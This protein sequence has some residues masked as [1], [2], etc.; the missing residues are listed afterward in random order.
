MAGP[1]SG[2]SK[3]ELSGTKVRSIANSAGECFPIAVFSGS[4]RT[5]NPFTCGSGGGDND[6]QQCFPSQAWGKRYLT[7]PTSTA[8]SAAVSMTNAYKIAVKDPTTNVFRN[9][10][11]IPLAT[12]QNGTYYYFESN[13]AQYITSDKPIMV[14]QYM[15]GGTACAGSGT[16]DPEMMYISPVEQGIK[17]V[18]FYRNTREAITVNYLTLIIPTAGISSL[19]IDGTNTFSH[20]Y[21][22]PQLPG[23]SV[24]VRR[25]TA[26]QSQAIVQSDSAFTAITYGLGG[27]ESYGYNAGTLINNLSAVGSIYNTSDTSTTTVSHPF[28]CTSTPVKLSVLLGY[29]TPPTRLVWQLSQVGGGLSPNTDI[30]QNNPSPVGTQVI[31][32]ISYFKFDLPTD[33]TFTTAGTY[34]IPL[35]AT[36]PSI[37]NCNN[38]ERVSYDIEVRGKPST[39]FAVT[40]TGCYLDTVFLTG[41]TVSANGFNINQWLYTFPDASTSVS[42]D[43]SKRFAA[44]GNYNVRLRIVSTE[45]CVGDTTKTISLTA[46][47]IV[48]FASTSP[49]PCQGSAFTFT[50][51]SSYT[52]T[53]SLNNS[54]WDF[55]DGTIV[56]ASNVAPI[57]HTYTSYGTF[58]VRHSAGAGASCIGDTISQTITVFAPPTTS[59]TYPA[60]CLPASGTVNFTSTASTPDGQAITGHLWNFGDPASGVNNTS[61]LPNPTHTYPGFGSYTITYR[62]TTANGCTKDTTVNATLNLA[63]TFNYP[64][65]A[66][67]CQNS[68]TPISVATATVTN[69]VPGAGIYRGPG[70]NAAGN[71]N[72][73]TAGAGA[74][75]IWY[76]YTTTANCIDSVSQTITVNPTPDASFAITTAA[77][78]PA[79]GIVPFNYN[80]TALPGQT[81]LWNFGD[82]ASGAN[83]TSTLANPTHNYTTGTYTISLRVTSAAGCIKDSVVTNTFNV[84]PALNYPA[85]A[86]VCESLTGTISVA[87]ATVTNGATGTGVYSGPGV[88]AAGNFSPSAAGDGTH[89]IWYVFTATGNCIDSISQTIVVHPTPDA[90]F[91][92]TT[93]ACLPASGIVPF[94]YNGTALPGQTYLWNFGDPASGLNN[95]SIIANPTHNYATGTYTISLR[96]TSA[97]GCVK[98]SVVTNTFSV[99][100]ALNYPA[101]AAVCESVVGTI[102]VATATVT[103][104][105]LGTGVYSGPGTDAA[106]NFNPSVAGPGT[107]TITYTFTST[108]NCVATTTQTI[109][110][111]AK[112]NASFTY[113]TAACLPTTGIATFTYNGTITA[114]QTYIWNFGDP[115]SGANNTST[116]A[117]PTH[118]YTNTG[119]YSVSVRVTNANGC[120][121]DSVITTTFSVTPALNYPALTAVCESVTGTVSVATAT[122]TN[123]VLGTGVYSGPGTDAAGN[124]NPSV[125]G[126]GTHTI[127]YTFTSTGNCVATTTQTIVVNAKPNASFTYPTASCLP[128]TGIAPF[129]YNGT[130][131]AGQTYLWNFGDPASGANNT[132]ALANPTHV[133]TNTGSYSLSVRV[134][135]AN[136]CFDDSVI[137]T[138]FSV[139]PS[140]NYPALTAVCESVVGTISVA[141]AT[142]TNGV[143]GT[144]VYSGPGTDAAGN[145]NPSV[146]GPGSHTITYTFTSTGNCVATTTQTIVVNAKPNASFTYPTAAC[147]PTTGIAQ[148][149]Y[150]GTVTAGQTYSWNFGDPASGANNT[151][152]LA[153]PT[154]VYT[155]TGSYSVSVTVTNANGCVD[156]SVITTTFSVTPA[157]NYPALTAVC[158]SITGTISVATATVTNGVL[159]TGVY[160]GSGTDAAGNFNPSVAGPGTHTITYTFTSTGNCVATTT[161]TIVVN[162]KPNA[163]FTYP[164]AACLPT[165]GI[166]QFTYNGTVTP[167]QTYLWNFGDPASGAN[168]TSALVNPTHTYTNTGSYSVSV[169]VTNA[170]G[171][172]DDSVITTT[173]SVTPAL[174]YPALTAVCESVTGTISVATATVT[175]GVL[176]TGVYSGP[177]TDAAGNFNPSVAGP[178]THTITYTFTSTGNCVATTTQTIVV[179]PKP[180]AAF[181]MNASICLG[182][183]A[184]IV[185]SS[186]IPSGTISSWNWNYGDGNTATYT[187][188][189]TYNYSYTTAGT[190]IVKL[191]TVSANGCVSDTVRQTIVVNSIPV[192]S[193]SMPSSVCMPNG[194]VT[195]TNNSTVAGGLGLTYVWNFG[196]ANS[197]TQTSPSHVYAAIN[198]YT[199]TL[200]ATSSAGCFDDSVQV[201]NA[202]F[203]KPIANFTVAPD[204]LCQGANNDFA[205]LS[206]APNSSIRSRLWIFGDG[207][208]STVANPTK[209]YNNPGSYTVKLVVINNESCVS[210]TFS[211][212]VRVYLQPVIDA[213]PSFIV[214]QGTVIRFNPTANDSTVTNFLWSPGFGLS[215]AATLRPTLT[216]T[217]DQTYTLTA[218]AEGNCTATDFLTV[219]IFRPVV[220]P[221]AFSPNGDNVNDRWQIDNLT[222]YTGVVVEVFN[223][224]G[225][226]VYTSNGYGTA[227]DGHSKGKPL[228]V[229]TYYYIIQLKNGFKPLNGSVTIIR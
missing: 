70:T 152:A 65:L 138:T 66:P 41:Q 69:G 139:T 23:Y 170:N 126:P 120:F 128:T 88:N 150:N 146:A 101:L 2:T 129:T 121:D 212:V 213:G 119:S 182:E 105:V 135:N 185:N 68:T 176:G 173:F 109:V 50:D 30:V 183:P 180:R 74:H 132:S 95:T 229:G 163:S 141:T 223:R 25:W 174:N 187:N 60:G 127:T 51:T 91:A 148:F 221:N 184:T 94:N 171:C 154:H 3:P 204:S 45:G 5:S 125:A 208:T 85:L 206:T 207:S 106:G 96:V 27:A 216:A 107:H 48:G 108:G 53:G 22:H 142:V 12:L 118:T 36:H 19:L 164:T 92:I 86:P 49:T 34:T 62:A 159:G 11:Q 15:T 145:F 47:P 1:E 89:T 198:P 140:L 215:N 179:N 130:V 190:Y 90:S 166:A 181:S 202:F 64:A 193:F 201:F 189:N 35:L 220:V 151:S 117:N 225:Q 7:A 147:L 29:E 52:G 99:T 209:R 14:A 40:S 63:P 219:K 115:A 217:T 160:S 133:Y 227:W 169:T 10:T 203:D 197:S 43:T 44:P 195:F 222:D 18:G 26:A 8:G 100:P 136:G 122:V 144:G 58:T 42:K 153:N 81:Y 224:Y 178:G 54:W 110:V 200:R 186:S 93:A 116:L 55:G 205:D 67:V 21:L 157:L 71:F 218:T 188:G 211:R 59:F 226:M 31:N 111:N 194:I 158:E 210:D 17:R 20:T 82:P 113:P 33:Y 172:V 103:N 124:F 24:V 104:G 61:T 175:N 177:G 161:Q 199:V 162:A 57:T 38:T 32:G 72:P 46:A 77:C 149:T 84:T 98:D 165:T 37:E 76:V 16:S 79:S 168:N 156:D 102:S 167:G 114:G 192:A 112:P 56:T 4:S 28:T 123:G 143:L 155:N 131:T 78:L 39:N 80:G 6:N 214:P 75:T 228:P 134:T 97:N 137:T 83:N 196:D 87:T 73:A 9:G 13:Q 191:V